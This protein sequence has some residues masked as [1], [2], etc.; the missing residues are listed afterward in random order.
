MYHFVVLGVWTTKHNFMLFVFANWNT[1]LVFV[2]PHLKTMH[3]EKV[4]L[5]MFLITAK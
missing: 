1:V 5:F 4:H 3:R 2:S